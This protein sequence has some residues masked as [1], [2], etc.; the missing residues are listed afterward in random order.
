MNQSLAQ[1]LRKFLCKDPEGV[2]ITKFGVFLDADSE[3]PP[4]T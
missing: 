3:S 4:M 1:I 2:K